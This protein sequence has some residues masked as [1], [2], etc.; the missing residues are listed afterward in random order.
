MASHLAPST[1]LMT[2]LAC[3][4]TGCATPAQQAG[5][6]VLRPVASAIEAAP[7]SQADLNADLPRMALSD[8][9]LFRILVGDV[10]AQ[11]GEYPLAYQAW[12]DLAEKTG[13]PR[14]AQRAFE[15]AIGGA[16][17]DEA[18]VAVKRW[19]ALAPKA[20]Q[21]QQLLLALLIRTNRI[22]EAEPLLIRLLE[23]QPEKLNAAILQLPRLWQDGSDRK[24]VVEIH[25]NLVVRYPDLPEASYALA[26]ALAWQGQARDAIA[27]LDEALR[28]RPD[29]EMALLYKAQLLPAAERIVFLRQPALKASRPAQLQ[30]AGALQDA[31]RSAQARQTYEAILRTWPDYIEALAGAG[32]L[33]LY[34][35]DYARADVLFK[36]AL[37][38][39]PPS[40][41]HLRAY[42]GQSA[43]MRM[44]WREALSW[45][46]QI[47]AQTTLKVAARIARIQARLGERDEALSAVAA[48]PESSPE[49]KLD[50]TQARGQVLREL[51]DYHGALTLLN[52][53]IVAMPDAHEL[54]LDRSL[55]AD[56]MGDDR[57][58]EADL[59]FYLDKRPDD[60][61]ALNALGYTLANR[62]VS[63]DEAE[64]LIG[65]AMASDPE[66]PAYID[67]L[68][69]LRYRQGRLVEARD[70]LAQAHA[71][72][73]D[74]EVSAHY[75]EVL[76]QNGERAKARSVLQTALKLTPDDA[77]LLALKKKLGP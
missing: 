46:R 42:L 9:I 75:A 60:A 2:L 10:A 34:A 15:V 63:L 25:R 45:Y 21:P 77:G 56:A 33:A 36:T 55:V 43:E 4:L 65:R 64:K 11:R 50:K 54:R 76:W 31:G 52:D 26:V 53:A 71:R 51:K 24:A 44:Q 62:A 40:A 74:P 18:I 70:L 29:W 17:L 66:N 73:P 48:M 22:A 68:G 27:A 35:G 16:L 32:L 37:T 72:F 1:F 5:A 38:Q 58:S 3:W 59:R 14:A 47:S 7:A 19:T 39:N 41:D 23:Q 8:E 28:L 49:E 61:S 20:E 57:L 6:P 69:W 30:L 13:D 67:S 12:M